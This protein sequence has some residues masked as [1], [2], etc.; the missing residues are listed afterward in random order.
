[1]GNGSYLDLYTKNTKPQFF[2]CK[3]DKTIVHPLNDVYGEKF[4]SNLGGMSEFEFNIPTLVRRNDKTVVNPLFKKL[5][6]HYL[7][8]MDKDGI[9]DYFTITDRSKSYN[10]NDEFTS[11]MAYSLVY[12]L[13]QKPIRGY[14]K[15]ASTLRQIGTDILKGT[16]WSIDYIDGEAELL[17][18]SMEISQGNILQS[19]FDL[20][21]KFGCVMEFNNKDRKMSFKKFQNVGMNRG[22]VARDEKYLE[23]FNLQ[24]DDKQVVTRLYAYGQDGLTFRSLTANGTNY[25]EDY[26]WFI[27]PFQADDNYN[28]IKHSNFM[29]DEL[30]IALIKYNK[31]LESTKP[32]FENLLAQQTTLD[33]NLRTREQE[34]SVLTTELKIINGEIDVIN[35]TYGIDGQPASGRPD[36]QDAVN[37]KNAKQAQIDSKNAEITAVKS[38]IDNVNL[39]ITNLRNTIDTKNNF[40]LKELEELNYYT[41]GTDYNNDAIVDPKDLLEEA[42]TVFEDYKQPPLSLSM[43]IETFT[44]FFDTRKYKRIELGDTVSLYSK[45]MD[46]NLSAR[47]STIEIDYETNQKSITVSNV[48]NNYS[49]EELEARIQ[50]NT[51]NA[52]STVNLDKYKWNKGEYAET[53][54]NQIIES[55]FDTAKNTLLGGYANS[56]EIT[57]R[58]L[59]T[60]DLND[61]NTFLVINNG[62][63]CITNDGGNSVAVAITKNGTVDS[64]ITNMVLSSKEVII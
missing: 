1:M 40:T 59:Y 24:I 48:R 51:I 8:R 19:M 35:Y 9:T 18:R 47:V 12:E 62:M 52:T 55:E 57:E 13:I 22:F 20:A 49:G 34:L 16:T 21:D 6:G 32:T 33:T 26:S 41:R 25:I 53:L 50:V 45:S 58:G 38:Q 5:Q 54:V 14:S 2:L 4:R 11:V 36:W 61:P 3:P 42:M 10:T 43:S 28:V 44:Q 29:T 30:C 31:L 27:Y 64:K 60:R 15:E 17:Y 7:I 39:Q 46:V 37:R 56:V 63:L 23:S